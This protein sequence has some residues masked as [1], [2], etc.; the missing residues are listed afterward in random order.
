MVAIFK[1]V[2]GKKHRVIITRFDSQENLD[3]FGEKFGIPAGTLSPLT[4][5]VTLP[6]KQ[7]VTKKVVSKKQQRT[8]TKTDLQYSLWQGMPY[9]KN[10]KNEAYAAIRFN[11]DT[12]VY[13]DEMFSD[14]YEQTI[15]ERDK[16]AR[17]PTKKEFAN[18]TACLRI[19]G[20]ETIT[21]YPM[22]IVSK[23]RYDC[24]KTSKYLTMN[25]TPHY[26]V[27][28][29]FEYE[30]YMETVGQSPYTTVLTIP[31]RFFD[32]YETLYDFEAKGE[33]RLTGPGA[34]RNFCW[35]HSKQE[36]HKAHHVL[37]D[38]LKGFYYIS[39]NCKIKTRTSAWIRAME[40][41]FD[42]C[43]NVAQM[44]PNYTSFFVK[45]EKKPPLTLNTRIY[46]W[47]LIRNDLWDEGFRWRGSWNED[48]ILSLDFLT[49]GYSTIQWNAFTQNKQGTQELRG[50]NTEEFYAKEG[51]ARKSQM[52]AD[53]YPEYARVVFKFSRIHHE[54]DYSPF[55]SIDPQ[56]HPERLEQGY[57]DYGMYMVK[58]RPEDDARRL[59]GRDTKSQIEANYDEVIYKLDGTNWQNGFDVY[60]DF[61]E[62]GY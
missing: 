13:S 21:R 44:G 62:K 59:T 43:D 14:I 22:Y 49:A 2:L 3:I 35:W 30:K 54:V 61:I 56:F 58:I 33:K 31:Q 47:I 26:V 48:T 17:Y 28:E 32:E 11:F 16:S 51:T 24:C 60:K 19:V 53:V 1:E 20:G 40:D 46:S 15:F 27:V 23:G 50:G 34:A 37:D 45:D 18:R 36:G 25:E 9:F 7:I 29:E 5:E 8:N 6:S 52:L 57:N 41:Y 55:A 39:H 38:N 12:E 10:E 4:K 42:A